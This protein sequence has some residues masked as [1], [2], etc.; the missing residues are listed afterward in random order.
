MTA[1]QTSTVP[2]CRLHPILSA[3]SPHASR[4]ERN[5]TQ[6]NSRQRPEA[7]ANRFLLRVCATR[8]GQGRCAR[9]AKAKSTRHQ[10]TLLSRR[11]ERTRRGARC[12]AD[13]RVARASATGRLT[14]QPLY[15]SL[16]SET[17]MPAPAS[18]AKTAT[19]WKG[20]P[21]FFGGVKA[22]GRTQIEWGVRYTSW[23]AGGA[24][25]S[26]DSGNGEIACSSCASRAFARRS[27]SA[28]WSS[29][30]A[31]SELSVRK[32][33]ISCISSAFAYGSLPN[34]SS[35]R[36]SVACA[37]VGLAGVAASSA[38]SRRRSASERGP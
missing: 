31:A 18:L 7:G 33:A 23:G 1:C 9:R 2:L 26:S 30:A 36:D 13:S 8:R 24:L 25:R 35:S 10:N 34:S 15:S 27:C 29:I 19:E 5:G 3:S 14:P 32:A 22:R 20:P 21:A 38:S 11:R 28:D 16:L 17:A 4:M 6:R 37:R 12:A